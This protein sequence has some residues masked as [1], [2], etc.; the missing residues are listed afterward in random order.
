MTIA[1]YDRRSWG[2]GGHDLD[3]YCT[4][5]PAAHVGDDAVF[6]SLEAE[7]RELVGDAAYE[8]LRDH[9]EAVMPARKRLP[10]T[11][12]PAGRKA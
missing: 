11:V 3:W 1:E 7:L 12:H 8:V 4:G 5:N 6:R 10:L 9:C 2:E